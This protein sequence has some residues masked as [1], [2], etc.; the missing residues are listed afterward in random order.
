MSKVTS[1]YQI[2]IPR[3]V[4][5]ELGIVPGAEVDIAKDGKRYILVVDPIRAVHSKWRGKFK[6]GVST[7]EYLNQIR[8]EVN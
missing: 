7:M 6:N 1:K 3:K 2:T 5:D 4:R 8:G